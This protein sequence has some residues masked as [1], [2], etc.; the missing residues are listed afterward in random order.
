MKPL[1]LFFLA[2]FILA[3]C[4][5]DPTDKNAPE[6]PPVETMF[7]DF[8]EMANMNKS[9]EFVK[10]NWIYSATTV[11]AWNSITWSAL[12]IPVA[13]FKSAVNQ[14]PEV[15]DNVTWTWQWQ[16]TVEGFNNEYT[17][18]LVGTLET[19][20]TVKWE[21]YI[22]K[23]GDSP[24][25]D[26][27]WF[28]G[29]SET[30]VKSGQW[31][32]YHSPE[33][34]EKVIEVDWIKEGQEVGEITYSYVRKLNDLRVEDKFYGSTLTFGLQESV[35]DAYMHLHAYDFESEQFEDTEIEWSRS[36]YSGRIKAE[37]F[38]QDTDWHCWDAEGNNADCS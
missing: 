7:M 16:Y 1:F 23:S 29:T 4:E 32:L 14:K 17:A 31:I 22:S 12:A 28:E 37:Q 13:A 5:K 33:Y 18:R 9:A 21:M 26:F 27:L 10:T 2:L 24:F 34:P 20:N 30:N 19:A 11:T 36:D 35:F 38:F 8:G 3:S 6:I 15:I 25:E